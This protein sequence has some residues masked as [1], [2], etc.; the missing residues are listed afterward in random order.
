MGRVSLTL[1][2]NRKKCE[3]PKREVS[4]ELSFY[5]DRKRKYVAT[6]VKVT[7]NEWSDRNRMVIR[8]KDANEL[9]AIL[10]TWRAKGLAAI[11]KMIDG[12][13]TDVSAIPRLM[14]LVE[15]GNM[16]FVEYCQKRRNDRH[17]SENTKKRYD[18][19]IGFL[20]RWDRIVW[21]SDCNVARVREMDEYLHKKGFEQ[22]TVASY[23]K[24]LKLF[25]N[26]A[27]ID[28][29]VKENP[30]KFLSFK[31]N[32]GE[33][34][35][36]DCITEEQFN[37]IRQLKVN[38]DHIMKAKDLFLFQCYTGLSFSDLM[39]FDYSC[40]EPSADGKLFYHSRRTKTDTDFV[41][42]LLSPAVEILD[43]Y[44]YILPKI[45]NQR[46]N[47]YLKVIGGLTGVPRLHS[48]MGR[49]TAATMFLSKGM[50][51]NVVAKV[52]GHTTLRQTTRYARTLNKD[53]K[54]AFD[55]IEGKI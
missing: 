48:H 38:S 32:K 28:G 19:F 41:F 22:S 37:A 26:D 47:D 25:I 2:H 42:Q 27:I 34:Q 30:Y 31:I 46:Y 4:V 49:A 9:N 52:L 18:V 45:S 39:S 5:C 15:G 29:F 44:N 1:I 53:V 6:N 10:D 24:Y 13:I 40:C 14:Q 11:Q 7:K 23:H 17:V 12:N 50:S 54:S 51:I 33:K 16:T 35:Y 36:V 3:D 21:F 8:R 43:R 20:Q 55:D